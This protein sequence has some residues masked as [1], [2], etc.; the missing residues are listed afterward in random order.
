MEIQQEAGKGIEWRNRRIFVESDYRSLAGQS[1]V[2]ALFQSLS[3][4]ES[5]WFHTSFGRGRRRTY[6]HT[7]A[8]EALI[9]YFTSAWRS[10]T[11]LQTRPHFQKRAPEF[12]NVSTNAKVSCASGTPY[13]FQYRFA[14]VERDESANTDGFTIDRTSGESPGMIPSRRQTKNLFLKLL[15]R[16]GRMK[17]IAYVPCARLELILSLYPDEK[18][19]IVGVNLVRLSVS[20]W[21]VLTNISRVYQNRIQRARW[22]TDSGAS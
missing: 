14:V 19:L 16:T 17:N 12:F 9:L 2:E 4:I 11:F 10:A 6:P 3:R 15:K 7:R 20:E 8:R 22:K 21:L 18:V 5:E 1:R 13:I